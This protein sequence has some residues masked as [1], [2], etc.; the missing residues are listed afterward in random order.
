MD[1]QSKIIDLQQDYIHITDENEQLKKEKDLSGKVRFERPYIFL[2]G[3][4]DPYCQRCYD[5]EGKTIGLLRRERHSSADWSRQC[6]KCESS[7]F[8]GENIHH[9]SAQI[10]SSP[11]R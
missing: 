8:E 1:L 11:R 6:P 7:F 9:P 3:D 10:S 5:D 2:E 4:P